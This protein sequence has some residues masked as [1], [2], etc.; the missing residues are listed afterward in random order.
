LGEDKDEDLFI[1]LSD[2]TS[3]VSTY[4]AGRFLSA[5]RPTNAQG[6]LDFNKLYHPPC[7]FSAYTS[8]PLPPKANQLAI[9]LHAGE[10]N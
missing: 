6:E 2:A 1:I 10:K 4:A 9:A 3:G 8:C 7:A 5:K